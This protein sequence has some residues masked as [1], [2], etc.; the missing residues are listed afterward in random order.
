MTAT[1]K[2]NGLYDNDDSFEIMLNGKGFSSS[3]CHWPLLTI[4]S[5]GYMESQRRGASHPIAEDPPDQHV[6]F[7][8]LSLAAAG[9]SQSASIL[10]QQMTDA[11]SAAASIAHKES[12]AN[13]SNKIKKMI[14]GAHYCSELEKENM[15]TQRMASINAPSTTNAA[16]TEIEDGRSRKIVH[17]AKKRF[18][19]LHTKWKEEGV[20]SSEARSMIQMLKGAIKV[21]NSDYLLFF[22][23]AECYGGIDRFGTALKDIEE[24]LLR[25]PAKNRQT[26]AKVYMK[27]AELLLQ[28]SST[29]V[30]LV[31]QMI[32][33]SIEYDANE[34][35]RLLCEGQMPLYLR[36]AACVGLGIAF[37][38]DAREAAAKTDSVKEALRYAVKRSNHYDHFV[39]SQYRD[40]NTDP[41]K[42][43]CSKMNVDTLLD[44]II[45]R[46]LRERSVSKIYCPLHDW[47]QDLGTENQANWTSLYVGNV[48]KN[49]KQDLQ[50]ILSRYEVTEC[51]VM[52]GST[53]TGEY[54]YSLNRYTNWMAPV[55]A[56][57]DL[58]GKL[59]QGVSPTGVES[60]GLDVKP[61]LKDRMYG[62]PKPVKECGASIDFR[63]VLA[64]GPTGMDDVLIPTDN[65]FLN[66]GLKKIK[67]LDRMSALTVAKL[68]VGYNSKKNQDHA[69][70]SVE[71][72]LNIYRLVGKQQVLEAVM[73][74]YRLILVAN[75][76]CLVALSKMDWDERV[77]ICSYQYERNGYMITHLKRGFPDEYV[78]GNRKKE[79]G[80]TMPEYRGNRYQNENYVSLTPTTS[81][82]V[83]R[84]F[85][86]LNK[87]L[88]RSQNGNG[89]IT[90]LVC[91]E[92]DGQLDGEYCEIK[93]KDTA[94]DLDNDKKADWCLFSKLAGHNLK[95]RVGEKR[96]NNIISHDFT[97]NQLLEDAIVRTIYDRKVNLLFDNVWRVIQKS[98]AGYVY[99]ADLGSLNP[100][101]YKV[102]GDVEKYSEL[103]DGKPLIP[104]D[105]LH[106]L[107]QFTRS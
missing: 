87:V 2:G 106:T 15:Q 8:R 89:K 50:D 80:T 35:F 53:P 22:H 55:F 51:N 81:G 54:W 105:L 49:C 44:C 36:Y 3:D 98:K 79:L 26:F 72:G 46:V 86:T 40:R 56:M 48:T 34:S 58:Q 64:G 18:E 103:Y 69:D 83:T 16:W 10:F 37:D 21:G 1:N 74:P 65:A 9:D 104:Y 6:D 20:D 60:W 47:Y 24:A 88:L 45:G 66:V 42:M 77:K 92:I 102:L 96:G 100:D 31:F 101:Y 82:L 4:T 12:K 14:P 32:E 78:D 97:V 27:K 62:A 59:V 23:R 7:S 5:A 93:Y 67:C 33:K 30:D 99:V 94:I 13:N 25:I 28:K 95:L 11:P 29:N 57:A 52:I 61:K 38:D 85:L 84:D 91:T 43:D 39:Y 63:R 76:D 75:R 41:D 73:K 70:K 17:E 19:L 90:M 71:I 68:D 107:D